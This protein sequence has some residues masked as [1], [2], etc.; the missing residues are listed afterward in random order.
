M[1]KTT[2][3]GRG[4]RRSRC[5][6][7]SKTSQCCT[8]STSKAALSPV[9]EHSESQT[10]QGS[11]GGSTWGDW[12]QEASWI[13]SSLKENR[14]VR[15]AMLL[16]QALGLHWMWLSAKSSVCGAC[17]STRVCADGQQII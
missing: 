11:S 9:Q 6:H 5:S 4:C 1:L 12:S 3:Q 2:S 16:F 7:S 14:Y 15:R 17:S 13:R 8:Q 10:A